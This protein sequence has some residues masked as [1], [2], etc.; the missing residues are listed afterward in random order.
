M[1]F[2]DTPEDDIDVTMEEVFEHITGQVAPDGLEVIDGGLQAAS[3][4]T[5]EAEPDDLLDETTVIP[6]TS[7]LQNFNLGHGM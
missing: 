7:T 2:T 1:E 3:T 5:E 4:F 6:S